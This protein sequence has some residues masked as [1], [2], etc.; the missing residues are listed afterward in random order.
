VRKSLNLTTKLASAL[1]A[2][3][4][5]KGRPLIEWEHAKLM[6][7]AQIISLFEFDHWPIRHEA[8]GPDEPWNLFPRFIHEHRIK[9][10]K[11]DVPEAA[12]IKRISKTEEEFRQRLLT[13]RQDRTPKRSKWPKR[14]MGR[15]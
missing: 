6:S 4:D 14:P 8:G 10:A 15:K 7:A 3:R 5:H 11:I 1:L 12:K 13:P 2:I 9:T